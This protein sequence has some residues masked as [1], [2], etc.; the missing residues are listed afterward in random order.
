MATIFIV[1]DDESLRRS[2]ART[3]RAE[4]WTVEA[5]ASAREFLQRPPYLGMGCVVL[6]VCLPELTGPELHIEMLARGIRLPVV[7]LTGHGDVPTSVS[8][9]KRGAVDF[10]TKPVDQA[11]LLCTVAEAVERHGAE[12]HDRQR[13]EATDGRLARL[14]PR[15]REVMNHVIAGSLNKQI[16]QSMGITLKTVKVHRAHVM[17]KMGVNSVAALVHLCDGARPSTRA[18]GVGQ[19]GSREHGSKVQWPH[20]GDRAYPQD[21]G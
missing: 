19:T 7:F 16:A 13:R 5:F 17:Q 15:E 6:D 3:L 10:L 4:G 2:L 9:M 12:R 8:A 21:W 1:D 18:L 20:T 11:T 14:S